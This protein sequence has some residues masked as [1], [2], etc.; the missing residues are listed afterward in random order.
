MGGAAVNVNGVVV[1]GKQW[2]VAGALRARLIAA[3]QREGIPVK[4]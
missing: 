2:E 3:F 1:P 4:G